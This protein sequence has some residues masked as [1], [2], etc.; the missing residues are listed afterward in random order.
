MESF[1]PRDVWIIELVLWLLFLATML[2]V[3]ISSTLPACLQSVE[4]MTERIF[5]FF[6][7][8]SQKKKLTANQLA[9]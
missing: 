7:Y 4:K 8:G 9:E 6:G 1:I 5:F 3:P 2:F